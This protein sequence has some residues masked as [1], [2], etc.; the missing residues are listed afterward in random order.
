MILKFTPDGMQSTFAM[1]L[2]N[3]RGLAFDRSGNLFVVAA[4]PSE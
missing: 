1:N 4:S 3:P 2:T